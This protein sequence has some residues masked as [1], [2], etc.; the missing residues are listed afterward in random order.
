MQQFLNKPQRA[1][2]AAD[3]PPKDDSEQRQ[4]AQHIPRSRM[5]RRVQCVLQRPKRAAG[6]RT[7]AG[8]AVE[9]RYTD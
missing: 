8:I 7:R 2:P 6:Y 1:D 5:S 4:D 3:R 9:S